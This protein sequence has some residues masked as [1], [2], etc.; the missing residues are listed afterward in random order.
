MKIYENFPP[1]NTLIN[2]SRPVKIPSRPHRAFKCRSVYH[3]YQRGNR[4]QRVFHS[5]AQLLSYLNRLDRLARRYKVR[6]H[7]FCLMS[8]HV[9]FIL[10]PLRKRGISNLMRD[11]QSQHAR[12]VLLSQR[13]DGHLWKHHF[14]ALPLSPSHYRAA[15]LYVEQNP[16]R[17]GLAKHAGDYPYSSAAAHLSNSPHLEI[18]HRKG[19]AHVGLY[20]KRWQKE[21]A[22][23]GQ[24]VDWQFWLDQPIDAAH[25]QDFAEI[26]KIL[27]PDRLTPVPTHQ[28]PRPHPPQ[29]H[30]CSNHQ[31]R[32]AASSQSPKNKAMLT[33]R[34]LMAL[35]PQF[36]KIFRGLGR[37]K[38]DQTGLGL[39]EALSIGIE[40]TV[41]LLGRPDGYFRNE[42]IKI[43]LPPQFK[44]VERAMR[45]AGLSG[46]MDQFV[47]SMNRA[48]EA[49]APFAKDIFV[50]AIKQITFDDA[51]R[52]LTGSDTAATEFFQTKTSRK[53]GEL[54]KPVVQKAMS[55]VGVTNQYQTLTSRLKT[56]PF[57][58]AEPL[59]LDQYVV[60]QAMKGLFFTLGEEEKKIRTNPAARVTSLLKEVFGNIKR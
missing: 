26:A 33:R 60:D 24:A 6:I 4:R 35:S 12:E 40:N 49:A 59:D 39:K 48:A 47:Q 30:P 50:S 46:V 41:Q 25:Q 28:L 10:E 55:E 13:S 56:I 19:F 54:F 38:E 16:V 2:V 7:A 22:A 42:L 17:A 58:K 32:P 20:L 53:L 34:L 57:V 29:P 36:D 31:V 5:Q 14:G 45:L 15:M 11:L 51:R 23:P 43:L 27:G 1:L 3:V 52:I 21:F 8:N 9:H 37:P 18:K 44:T